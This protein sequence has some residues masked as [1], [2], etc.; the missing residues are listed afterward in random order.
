MM[1]ADPM[2]NARGDR[3]VSARAG[4]V[5]VMEFG[6]ARLVWVG[7]EVPGGGAVADEH[8]LPVD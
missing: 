1:V 6:A 8:H 2:L 3:K 5:H 7:G 4:R